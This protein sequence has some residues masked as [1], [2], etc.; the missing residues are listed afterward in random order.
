MNRLE[1]Q[2]L[3]TER[4]DDAAA[5]LNAGRY[6]AAYYVSGYAIECA[7]KA[8]IARRTK[9]DDF[10]PKEASKYYTHDLPKLLDMADL[11]V[12]FKQ[13]AEREPAFRSNWAVVKDWTEESRYYGH[14][15]RD[16]EQILAA[17]NDPHHGVLRWLRQNW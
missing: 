9:Q 10:P 11:G 7:L 2:S 8:C 6:A 1:F 15:Q 3:A 12:A 14:G 13:E 4:L 5:L 17:I 16:A